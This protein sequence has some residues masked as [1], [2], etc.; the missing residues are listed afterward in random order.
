MKLTIHSVIDNLNDS[1]LPDGEPEINI[2]TLDADVKVNG[3]TLYLR[4][5]E[6][7]EGAVTRTLITAHESGIRLSKRGAVEW[8]TNF[9]AGEESRTLY[10]IP[11]YTFD[12]DI[13]T[14]R[15]EWTTQG[16]GHILRLIYSMNIG[17]AEK[18]VK[19]KMTLK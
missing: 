7:A 5:T 1:G 17:G 16:D 2:V 19:I 18:S 11:P 15:A 8:E 9:I 10:K 12:A 6:E 14:S 3:G 13:R 4:Y